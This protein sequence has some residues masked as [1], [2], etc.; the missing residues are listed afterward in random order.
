M[1]LEKNVPVEEITLSEGSQKL[2][3]LKLLVPSPSELAD[4]DWKKKRRKLLKPT[5]KEKLKQ[6]F[7]FKQPKDRPES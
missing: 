1:S 4:P 5:L 6:L 2:S 7:I 3:I